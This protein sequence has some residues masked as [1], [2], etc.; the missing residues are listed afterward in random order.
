MAGRCQAR[1][2]AGT[3]RAQPATQTV[4]ASLRRDSKATAGHPE[5]AARGHPE[6]AARGHPEATLLRSQIGTAQEGHRER[7]KAGPC[8]QRAEAQWST[9]AIPRRLR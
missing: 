9:G 3:K 1:S 6:A 5:A 4:K 2:P 7:A 8:R